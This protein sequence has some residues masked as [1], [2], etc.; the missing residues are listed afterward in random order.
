MKELLSKRAAA[1]LLAMLVSLPAWAGSP[2][3]KSEVKVIQ[4]T[5][6]TSEQI[7]SAAGKTRTLPQP[8]QANLI[9]AWHRVGSPIRTQDGKI[10]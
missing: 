5:E 2:V 1:W 8:Q 4:E 7:Q 3:D 10:T 9:L 6:F